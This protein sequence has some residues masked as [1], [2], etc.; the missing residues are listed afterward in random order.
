MKMN[1]GKI[2][3]FSKRLAKSTAGQGMVE[4]ILIL[5]VVVAIV[6]VMKD[7]LKQYVSEDMF[8][9]LKGQIDNTMNQ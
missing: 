1:L 8:N 6:M 9:N 7:R 5:V 3:A 4:Y 2:K